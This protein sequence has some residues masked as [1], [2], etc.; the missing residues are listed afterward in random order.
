MA[1]A[2]SS[3][4]LSAQFNARLR[5]SSLMIRL[6]A[7]VVALFVLWSAFAW[8]DEIVRAPGE[9]ISSSRPQIIQN[10]EGGILSELMVEEGDPVEPGDVIARLHATT[11]DSTV[12]DI[13]DQIA[14]LEIR[15]LRLEAE[16]AGLDTFEVPENLARQVPG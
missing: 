5:G 14:A 4:N 9:V 11:Y 10:L 15:R 16:L 8:L 6:C 12:T 13:A 7:A 2:A 3:T 1:A